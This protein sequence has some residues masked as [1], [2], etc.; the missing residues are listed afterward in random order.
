MFHVVAPQSVV[1]QRHELRIMVD[2]L[3]HSVSIISSELLD[4]QSSIRDGSLLPMFNT[5]KNKRHY[6]EGLIQNFQQLIMYFDL[7]RKSI[8]KLLH[9]TLSL[10]SRKSV[11][12]L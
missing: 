9:R 5:K 11:E 1:A 7:R 4:M 12:E 8:D 2:E 6:E 10:F 3:T